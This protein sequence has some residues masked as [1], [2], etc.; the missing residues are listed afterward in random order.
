MLRQW[1]INPRNTD[2]DK[3]KTEYKLLVSR[4]AFLQADYKSLQIEIRK[5]Q[6][7]QNNL[8]QYFDQTVP[9]KQQNALD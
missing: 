8:H 3:L 2:L 1:G 6:H 5:L 9:R 7:K 4:K